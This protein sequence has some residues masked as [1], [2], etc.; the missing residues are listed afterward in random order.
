MPWRG[1]E[2]QGELRIVPAVVRSAESQI[3]SLNVQADIVVMTAWT[4]SHEIRRCV[5]TQYGFEHSVARIIR[6]CAVDREI[7]PSSVVHGVV[8]GCS[9]NPDGRQASALR[10][11]ALFRPDLGRVSSSR[12][13]HTDL[14]ARLCVRGF[15]PLGRRDFR[16][17]LI[18]Q[19]PGNE[20]NGLRERTV[21]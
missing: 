21:R 15:A 3:A 2:V 9:S 13:R 16:P 7:Q 1:P 18:R 12:K 10:S 4:E 14:R 5:V 8:A 20:T 6:M 11:G 17:D 19:V